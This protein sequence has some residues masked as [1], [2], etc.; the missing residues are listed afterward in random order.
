MSYKHR[1]IN[2]RLDRLEEIANEQFLI[3]RQKGIPS[4]KQLKEAILNADT[5]KIEDDRPTL[6]EFI[7]QLIETRSKSPEYAYG[8][9]KVYNNCFNH[10]KGFS[11][12]K[13]RPI[14]WGDISLDF[15]DKW[16]A[17]MYDKNLAQNYV[18][19]MVKT[20]KVFLNEA[21]ER[22][23]TQNEAHTSRK[24][25]VPG[26]ETYKVYLLPE[27]IEQ[28]YRYDFSDNP[29][30]E[31]IRDA[32]IANYYI[33]CRYSDLHKVVASSIYEKDGE[34]LLSYTAQKT[35]TQVTAPVD[36]Y[37]INVLEKYDGALP[38]LPTGQKYNQYIK[39]VMQLAGINSDVLIYKSRGKSKVPERYQKWQLVSS[40]T[41][42]HSFI[43]NAIAAGLPES[44]IMKMT[45]I[46]NLQTLQRHYIRHSL[47]ENAV[48]AAKNPFFS[49]NRNKEGGL[50]KGTD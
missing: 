39:E 43:S 32:F 6:F 21:R 28:V 36:Q 35:D 50:T 40:H 41:A 47:E 16:T 37:V 17:Y 19:K 2:D 1:P 48:L 49:A 18:Q 23:H 26:T 22:G 34:L 7:A 9:S 46:K 29:R 20:L 27:E 12:K 10:L 15:L 11:K 31:R 30:L 24:F 4:T 13:R 44:I 38:R 45:G 3:L 33:G 14:H 5:G 8:T 25:S 42:R